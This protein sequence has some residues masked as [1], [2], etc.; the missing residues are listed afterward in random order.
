VF[1]TLSA[2][3]C[4]KQNKLIGIPDGGLAPRQTGRVT[5][6]RTINLI[7]TWQI[8]ER[9]GVSWLV[10]GPLPFSPCELLL[11]EASRCGTEIVREPRGRGAPPFEAVT[12]RLVKTQQTEKTEVCSVVNC[13]V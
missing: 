3:R 12:R 6:G 5:V 2:P 1:S 13:R 7:L 9:S 10:R 4:F 8:F 11:L